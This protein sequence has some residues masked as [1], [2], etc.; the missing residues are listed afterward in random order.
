MVAAVGLVGLLGGGGASAQGAGSGATTLLR[1]APGP[2]PLALGN[3][4]VAVRG[5][6]ALE[7]NPAAVGGPGLAAAYQRLP[8]GVNAGALTVAAPIGRVTVGGSVRYLDY[9]DVAV[10]ERGEGPIGTPTG[11]TAGG[12]ELSALVGVGVAV[13]AVR[14]G[15]AGRWL[16]QDVAGLTDGTVALDAGVL[17]AAAEWL[18]L[19]ASVQHLGPD[20]EAGR[21]AP[22]PRTVRVGAAGRGRVAG[23]DVLLA[24]EARQREERRGA[25]VGLEIARGWDDLEAAFRVGWETRPAPGDAFSPLVVGGGVRLGALGVELAWRA[26][27][28]L[29]SIRQLGVRYRF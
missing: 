13:G 14:A 11:G 23:L 8:T 21:A 25:G 16:H 2:R 18:D 7:F 29:G 26:L 3:A 10:V 5:P 17:V 24:A 9:G 6:L 27:G 1:V 28:A 19:G 4:Y 12:G 22:L 20:V 15:L